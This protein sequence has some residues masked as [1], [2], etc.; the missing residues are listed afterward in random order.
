M[1][2]VIAVCLLIFLG[3]T[4]LG[5]LCGLMAVLCGLMAGM[6][7]MVRETREAFARVHYRG[8]I[9]WPETPPVP[10]PSPLDEL[11]WDEKEP[12]EDPRPARYRKWPGR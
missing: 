7:S 11:P 1:E 8:D 3:G 10:G 4:V 2:I 6:M 12:R 9:G 5:I